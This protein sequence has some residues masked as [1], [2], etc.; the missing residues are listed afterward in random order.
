MNATSPSYIH[1]SELLQF[2]ATNTRS[3]FCCAR[4]ATSFSMRTL[5]SSWIRVSVALEREDVRAT[6]LFQ[7]DG[8]GV[9]CSLL[10]HTQLWDRLI[11]ANLQ[12]QKQSETSNLLT[13]DSKNNLSKY[14]YRPTAS[15][16][17]RSLHPI[18]QYKYPFCYKLFFVSFPFRKHEISLA[19]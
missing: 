9:T 18:V 3:L 5:D 8:C 4:H 10:E 19:K 7:E 16:L 2:V 1:A 13:K 12:L 6:L 15:F 14:I 17:F 11:L